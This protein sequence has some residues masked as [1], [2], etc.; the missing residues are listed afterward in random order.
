[1]RASRARRDGGGYKAVG[2]DL[3]LPEVYVRVALAVGEDGTAVLILSSLA[4]E[5]RASEKES[6]ESTLHS[7]AEPIRTGESDSVQ[8]YREA[9]ERKEAESLENMTN[10]PPSLPPSPLPMHMDDVRGGPG[11]ADPSR[12]EPTA[13]GAQT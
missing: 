8:A 12:P 9:R 1:M 4:S 10:A 7:P 13:G 6:V 5:G 11:G 2:A 3:P